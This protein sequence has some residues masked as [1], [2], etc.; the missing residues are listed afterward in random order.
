[1]KRKG[2][3]EVMKKKLFT[4]LLVLGLVA[5]QPLTAGAAAPSGSTSVTVSPDDSGAYNVAP[6]SEQFTGDREPVSSTLDKITQF[7][8]SQIN[9]ST[10]VD[11]DGENGVAQTAD[12]TAA[13]QSALSGKTALTGVLD[14]YPINGGT[15][16]AD[17][18]H[19]LTFNLPNL[20]RAVKNVQILHYSLARNLWELVPTEVNYDAKTVTGTFQDL[21]PVVIVADVESSD[22]SGAQTGGGSGSSSG[23]SSGSGAS[24]GAAQSPK[25]GETSDWMTW[26][27]AAVVFGA[28]AVLVR[29]QKRA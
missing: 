25:T 14:A 27:G 7:N 26:V 8:S 16:D 28:A 10:L 9:L 6:A 5:A 2:R 3:K 21:S 29:K 19:I 20:T 22:G 23:S 12:Q 17:G 13:L 15:P 4:L 18:N 24:E 11:V 1:M